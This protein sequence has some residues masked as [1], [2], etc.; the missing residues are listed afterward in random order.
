MSVDP[1]IATPTLTM[2]LSADWL[3]GGGQQPLRNLMKDLRTENDHLR[4]EIAR[5]RITEDE[6]GAI[7]RAK[8]LVQLDKSDADTLYELLERVK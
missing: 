1:K 6:R 4:R 5:L 8:A 7:E 2:T 3:A